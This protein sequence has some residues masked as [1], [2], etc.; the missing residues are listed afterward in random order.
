MLL[1][2]KVLGIIT[3]KQYVNTGIKNTHKHHLSLLM[4]NSNNNITILLF[5]KP[6]SAGYKI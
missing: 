2:L 6:F 1:S 5:L 3:I 4:K